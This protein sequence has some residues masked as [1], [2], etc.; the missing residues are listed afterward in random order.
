MSRVRLH[1]STALHDG[2]F[3][4]SSTVSPGPLLFT[5]G[6][7]PLDE[8][9]VVIAPG[10]VLTQARA[11]LGNLAAVL[12]EQGAALSDVAKLTVYVAEHLQSDLYVAWEAV[13]AEFDAVPPTMM[14]GVSVLPYDGQVVEVDAVA[15]PPQL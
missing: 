6:I 5:A 10:D 8:N 15:A 9:G 13:S 14:M 7:S 3:P 1:G 11:C 12:G 2:G 4:Y